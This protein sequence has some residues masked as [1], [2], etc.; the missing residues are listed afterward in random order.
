M[1]KNKILKYMK[2]LKM[3]L[4]NNNEKKGHRL[5]LV[6][7]RTWF[8]NIISGTGSSDKSNISW[9]CIQLQNLCT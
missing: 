6:S 8:P 3:P 7:Y 1:Q 4:W 2:S 9:D 5:E